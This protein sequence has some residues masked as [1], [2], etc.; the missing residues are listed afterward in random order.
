MKI[1]DSDMVNVRKESS[2]APFARRD[3]VKLNFHIVRKE[4]SRTPFTPSANNNKI[5][6]CQEKIKLIKKRG[7]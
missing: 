4:S 5:N 3:T 1:G 6:E 7:K 2:R